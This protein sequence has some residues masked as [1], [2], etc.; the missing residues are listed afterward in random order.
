MVSL[1]SGTKLATAAQKLFN[2]AMRLN[3]IGLIVTA[4]GLAAIANLHMAR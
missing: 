2:L 1:I 4:L 3:P